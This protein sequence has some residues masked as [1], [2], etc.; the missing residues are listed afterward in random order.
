MKCLQ[1]YSFLFY[2]TLFLRVCACAFRRT[3]KWS[4]H[5]GCVAKGWITVVLFE[6]RARIL[7]LCVCA[8]LGC[9]QAKMSTDHNRQ[10]DRLIDR[11]KEIE[12]ETDHRKE[13]GPP[14]EMF[15]NTATPS[16]TASQHG[17]RRPPWVLYWTETGPSWPST[18][19]RLQLA[20]LFSCYF[21]E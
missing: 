8:E 16:N 11:Q 6:Q 4:V 9:P 2:S 13:T 14:C 3:S 5:L 17:G 20:D 1:F 12:S 21:V 19:S 10:T 15:Q 18:A 7:C